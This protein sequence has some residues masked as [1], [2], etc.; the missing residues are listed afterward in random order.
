MLDGEKQPIEVAPHPMMT[1]YLPF[2]HA[3]PVGTLLRYDTAQSTKPGH[4]RPF[5]ST[6]AE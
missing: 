2:S 4:D 1:V 6:K 3:L 5:C